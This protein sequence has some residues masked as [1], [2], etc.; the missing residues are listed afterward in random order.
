MISVT[1]FLR[2]V[3]VLDAV[4]S[5]ATG[6]LMSLGAGPLAPILGL[7]PSLLLGAGLALLPFA[8]GVGFLA[9]RRRLRP[10]AMWTLIGLN[11]LWVVE[12]VAL[13]LGG[14]VEATGLGIA[15]VLGQ[16][17]AVAVLAELQWLGCRRAARA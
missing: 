1:P 13:L 4:A 11:G 15:F 12:S 9:T 10:A 16:A 8:A 3:L 7:P 5:G 6:L 2:R 14:F 17:A